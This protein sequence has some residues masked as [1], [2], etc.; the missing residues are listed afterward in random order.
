M[1]VQFNREQLSLQMSSKEYSNTFSLK[2]DFEIV[3]NLTLRVADFVLNNE[4][5]LHY[6][7]MSNL[8]ITEAELNDCWDSPE[9]TLK[10][11]YLVQKILNNVPFIPVVEDE[12]NF[13]KETNRN[14][15]TWERTLTAREI[16]TCGFLGGAD[17]AILS[18]ENEAKIPFLTVTKTA[19]RTLDRYTRKLEVEKKAADEKLWNERLQEFRRKNRRECDCILS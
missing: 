1:N 7:T 9:P 6:T 10:K 15:I 18:L 13:Q 17:V 2:S 19:K 16:S 5:V 14:L 12:F 8:Q 4:G 11:C 3:K